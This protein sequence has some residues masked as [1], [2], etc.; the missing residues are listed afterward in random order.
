MLISVYSAVSLILAREK[1]YI[2]K[3]ICYDYHYNQSPCCK[4]GHN[5][6]QSVLRKPGSSVHPM[7]D[8]TV[9]ELIDFCCVLTSS[10][11]YHPAIVNFVK[12]YRRQWNTF[13]FEVSHLGAFFNSFNMPTSCTTAVGARGRLATAMVWSYCSGTVI[14]PVHQVWPKPSCKAE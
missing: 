11:N 14:S 12:R 1:R 8:V 3:K 10:L 5:K 13:L 2:K 7:G 6:N 4:P 9:Q